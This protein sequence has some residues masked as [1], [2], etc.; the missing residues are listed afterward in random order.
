VADNACGKEGLSTPK[1]SKS[2]KKKGSSE[3]R[4]EGNQK[5][6]K[7]N[8]TDQTRRGGT[9][10]YPHPRKAEWGCPGDQRRSPEREKKA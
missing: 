5:L 7:K 4:E 3:K 1:A 8:Q 9:M 2:A 6:K 10:K